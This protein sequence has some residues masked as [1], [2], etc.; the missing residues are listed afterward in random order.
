MKLNYET[1]CL[2]YVDKHVLKVTL[3]RPE[4][5]NARN[6]KMGLEQL[7]LMQSLYTDPKDTRCVVITGRGD[8]AF[9]A[10][11][12]LKERKS[13]TESDWH[14]QHAIFEQCVIATRLCPVPIIAAVNGVAYGGGCELALGCDFIYASKTA[15]FALTEV[16]LGIMPG[17][18]GTQNLPHA[19][20]ERRA[21]EIILTGEV[22]TADQ[23][24]SWNMVNK[25]C[26]PENLIDQTLETANCI[27]KNAPL[28]VRRAKSS[29][30]LAKQV[31]WQSGF[32]FELEAYN[33]LIGTEDRIEGV[34]AF[35]EKRFP[36]FKGR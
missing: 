36:D 34:N 22:F 28:S 32:R 26:D 1:L 18:M 24:L 15:L 17:A 21:K 12:D 33:R 14:R 4:V 23:A 29:L 31:D 10:G 11:G 25:V 13:M 2:E 19:V 8:R 6:T 5:M 16:K 3:D 35:N 27:A 20:G 7:D 9:S 30:S